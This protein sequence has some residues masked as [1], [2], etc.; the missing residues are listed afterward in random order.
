MLSRGH[1]VACSASFPPVRRPS[2]VCRDVARH[3]LTSGV[4]PFF[5]AD[6]PS[7]ANWVGEARDRNLVAR[8]MLVLDRCTRLGGRCA[9]RRH[10]PLNGKLWLHAKQRQYLVIYRSWGLFSHHNVQKQGYQL[11]IQMCEPAVESLYYC[12]GVLSKPRVE[13]V[14]VMSLASALAHR[15]GPPQKALLQAVS[16][17]FASHSS[18]ASRRSLP[19]VLDA[20]RGGTGS[21]VSC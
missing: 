2:P 16:G 14:A 11:W 20:V 9:P 1:I 7:R 3:C 15:S 5:G 8:G 6:E 19:L 21:L 17:V 13:A 4:S 12:S 10:A 18:L